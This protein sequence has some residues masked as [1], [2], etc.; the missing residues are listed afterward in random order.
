MQPRRVLISL[1]VC[2]FAG[3][4]FAGDPKAV[5]D[6]KAV[7]ERITLKTK[8]RCL[9]FSPDGKTLAVGGGDV[10]I[11]DLMTGAVVAELESG[12]GWK[13]ELA[14]NHDGSRLAA[15]DDAGLLQVW[16][17]GGKK[18]IHQI[19]T[20]KKPLRD[21]SF[22]KD[23]TTVRVLSSGRT[24]DGARYDCGS[25]KPV[26]SDPKVDY[27]DVFVTTTNGGAVLGGT[28]NQ[29]DMGADATFRK[30]YPEGADTLR[31]PV[32]SEHRLSAAVKAASGVVLVQFSTST[33][34][35]FRTFRM[36]EGD[37][38]REFVDEFYDLTV[39]CDRDGK[40][41]SSTITE[42]GVTALS[43]SPDGTRVAVGGAAGELSVYEVGT[44]KKL[45]SF[46]RKGEEPVE[47]LGFSRD[48]TL[49]ACGYRDVLGVKVWELAPV[50]ALLRGHKGVVR[51]LAVSADEK[52]LASV[53]EEDTCVWD[54]ET[55]KRLSHADVGGNA[56]RF[57]VGDTLLLTEHQSTFRSWK[58]DSLTVVDKKSLPDLKWGSNVGRCDK[59]GVVREVPLKELAGKTGGDI[60]REGWLFKGQYPYPT[61]LHAARSGSPGRDRP[62]GAELLVQPA[63][64]SRQPR[65]GR[66]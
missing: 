13:N 39:T 64:G 37:V 60:A 15:V 45:V 29:W 57:A 34:S 11:W 54:L 51:A 44:L 14:Y 24:A 61:F 48:G 32:N 49:L 58:P 50:G 5:V 12:K 1:V 56:V 19:D 3:P 55:G 66:A 47:A 6:P 59:D 40:R 4:V 10:A 27:G 8:G 16:D 41:V 23:G 42:P 46:K 21:V 28:S 53:A 26:K 63:A 38:T 31:L 22:S 36:N 17:V 35:R 2:A 65:R 25:G 30:C 43:L 7:G 62:G 52:R 18:L 9:K 20:G 33:R